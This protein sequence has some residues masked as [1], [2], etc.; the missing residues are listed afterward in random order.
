[1]PKERSVGDAP[2]E[3]AVEETQA[4][5]ATEPSAL[6]VEVQRRWQIGGLQVEFARSTLLSRDSGGS[7]QP[8]Q[9]DSR[10]WDPDLLEPGIALSGISAA[11]AALFPGLDTNTLPSSSQFFGIC[12]VAVG[13]WL[14]TLVAIFASISTLWLLIAYLRGQ[15]KPVAAYWLMWVGLLFLLILALSIGALTVVSTRIGV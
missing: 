8:P 12:L 5:G 13:S 15:K 7:T 11:I 4:G 14:A 1:M 2:S 10:D 9:E 3:P 6:L